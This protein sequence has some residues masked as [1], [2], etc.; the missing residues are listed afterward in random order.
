MASDS[1]S[2]ADSES[3]LDMITELERSGFQV[4]ITRHVTSNPP[5]RF[6]CRLRKEGLDKSYY[7]DTVSLALAKAIRTIRTENE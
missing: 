2:S 3:D 5:P 1:G 6:C 7:G 4:F